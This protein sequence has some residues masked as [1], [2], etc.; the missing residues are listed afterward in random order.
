MGEVETCLKRLYEEQYDGVLLMPMHSD[1]GEELL[2]KYLDKVPIVFYNMDNTHLERLA[3][4]GCD[5]EQAG[6]V[7]AGLAALCSKKQGKVAVY[8][9]GDT[10]QESYYRR[11]QGFESELASQYKRME[12]TASAEKCMKCF[13][14]Q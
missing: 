14:S 9:A 4:V 11:M 6:R 12:I 8:T 10:Q 3:Y 7:A 2:L 1:I 5:Y 13:R